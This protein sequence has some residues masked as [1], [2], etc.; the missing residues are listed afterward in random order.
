MIGHCEWW[1]NAF[2]PNNTISSVKHGGGS[3]VLWG[4]IMK[5]WNLIITITVITGASGNE[6]KFYIIS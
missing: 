6:M 2:K 3:I 5:T 4:E 1:E